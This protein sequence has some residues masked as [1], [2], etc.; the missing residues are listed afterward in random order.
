VKFHARLE[1][2]DQ[3]DG[4]H[5]IK[6]EFFDRAKNG[7]SPLPNEATL[8]AGDLRP[9]LN[10]N[11][12]PSGGSIRIT[13]DRPPFPGSVLSRQPKERPVCFVTADQPIVEPPPQ[14]TTG[15]VIRPLAETVA[16]TAGAPTTGAAAT[17][18]TGPVAA[19]VTGPVAVPVTGPVAV[20]VTGPVAVPVTGPVAV[21]VTGPLTVPGTA[22]AAADPADSIIGYQ[23]I[24]LSAR[25][26]VAVDEAGRALREAV[27]WVPSP[28]ALAL[29]EQLSRRAEAA[30]S[31]T[32]LRLTLRGKFIWS[33]AAERQIYL[34]G[35][36]FG[37]EGPNGEIA[38]DLKPASGDGW[39]GGDFDM[40]FYL[41]PTG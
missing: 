29:L 17:P 37:V 38:L 22:P 2:R 23:S 7:Y 33:G 10:A 30:H 3:Q 11:G 13:F 4:I 15:D 26:A 34:D 28:A 24:I 21:P 32:R 31:A 18:V 12:A 8:Q 36:A 6:V 5:I 40:W 41:K 20:P 25:V 39:H 1:N 16:T 35:E 9:P 19:P 27:D 14:L